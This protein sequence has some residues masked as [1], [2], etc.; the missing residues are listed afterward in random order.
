MRVLITGASGNLGT[1]IL[2][3]L[4]TESTVDGVVGL[5]RR[6]PPEVPPYEGVP[7]HVADLSSPGSAAVLAEA[8]STVDAVVHLAWQL[9]SSPG[10]TQSWRTNVLGSQRVAEEAA[11]AAGVRHLVHASSVGAYSPGQGFPV[12][13]RWPT[14]GVETSSYS[15]QKAEVE[16]WLDAQ[17]QRLGLAVAR[18]RPALVFQEEAGSEVGRYFIG[19]LFSPRAIRLLRRTR[20]PVLPL[21]SGLTVQ[22]VHAEDVADAVARILARRATGAFN[23]AADPLTGPQLARLAGARHLPVP[24][25][26]MRGGSSGKSSRD[27]CTFAHRRA[28]AGERTRP[29]GAGLAPAALLEPGARR[30]DPR[31]GRGRRHRQP[32]AA[33]RGPLTPRAAAP[34]PDPAAGGV[35]GAGAHSAPVEVGFSR[36]RCATKQA[37]RPAKV[38][39][40]PVWRG[41]ARPASRIRVGMRSPRLSCM[42]GLRCARRAR[43]PWEWP[44]APPKSI[45]C[46]DPPGASTRRTSRS[47]LSRS[48]GSRWWNMNA[49][50]TRSKAPSR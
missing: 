21:P 9:Q 48:A 11:A 31:D 32:R 26:L 4:A 45:R 13:E 7:W 20:L 35:A 22:A 50:S 37:Y 1:A 18:I 8:M 3:R 36:Q 14:G 39:C 40:W 15:Q 12:D 2:R 46:S 10:S 33:S 44:P 23:L 6:R 41:L 17:E 42:R 28:G 5:S 34:G 43:I 49:D 29:A 25:R 16:A 38:R 24:G 19:P 47:A 30:S 27:S